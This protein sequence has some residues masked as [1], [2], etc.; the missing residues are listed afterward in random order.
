MLIAADDDLDEADRPAADQFFHATVSIKALMKFLNSY[1]IGGTAIACES[2]I[3]IDA[4]KALS[5][6]NE[7]EG[8]KKRIVLITGICEN[9]CVIA[10]VYIG[11]LP[12]QMRMSA[13]E[14]AKLQMVGVS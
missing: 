8:L 9:H 4:Q 5:F 11:K 6:E 3:V 1:L 12:R 2:D 10:Y 13:N 14:Q 7:R